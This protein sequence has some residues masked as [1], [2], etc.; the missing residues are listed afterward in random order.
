MR[1]KRHTSVNR[2]Q[3]LVSPPKELIFIHIVAHGEPNDSP[4]GR[5]GYV[6]IPPGR[7]FT[8]GFHTTNAT[9]KK[10]LLLKKPFFDKGETTEHLKAVWLHAGQKHISRA[11]H[12]LSPNS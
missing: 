1:S 7:C 4:E 2:A 3:L 10:Q 9:T 12:N 5:E 6:H 11:L 8:N